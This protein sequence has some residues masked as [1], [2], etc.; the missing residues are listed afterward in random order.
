MT[1]QPLQNRPSGEE[2]LEHI[3][4]CVI[5]T[6]LDGIV[7]YWNAASERIFGYSREEMLGQP[8]VKI[9][10]SIVEDQFREDLETIKRNGQVEGKRKSITKD[11]R[12][13]WIDVHAMPFENEKGETLAVVAS[14]HDIEDLKNIENELEENKARAQAILETT[15]DGII[16]IDENA[17]I[18]S[19]NRAA[20]KI[21]G[22]TEE[23]VLGKNVN[24]LMPE[25]H[26]SEHDSFIDR[27]RKTGVRHIIGHRRELTGQR[28]DG[29][30][31]PL[32]LSVSEVQWKDKRIF[33][34]VVN[35]ISERRRLE[36]EILRISEEE[37]RNLGQDLHDGLGQML[38]GISLISKNLAL[39]LRAEGITSADEVL[40]IS[41][42]VKE[43][44]EYAKALAHG[45]VHIDFKEEGLQNALQQLSTQAKKL[46]NVNC[47]FHSDEYT[48]VD[49]SMKAMNLYRIAQEAI[50]NAVK[51]G[52]AENIDISLKS[53]NG[54]IK[55]SIKD[56]G[57]GF[58][59]SR[60]Q[61]KK[62]G[63]GIYIMQY[64]T[65]MMSGDFEISETDNQTRIKC[66]IPNNNM[67]KQNGK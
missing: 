7:T 51:H 2:I 36:K 35:D 8:L 44:D 14:A 45:L 33:T 38:T 30:L 49:N 48:R 39:K 24:M 29:S 17:Q 25:P 42:L 32:E 1:D 66:S 60:K 9:Y 20:T 63:M 65:N 4:Q 16:T 10:P 58:S 40:E 28:K 56:D 54:S 22:F 11:G 43:A 19:F 23:D 27:Y 31:F 3:S 50:S 18:L 5:T 57:I 12:V 15:V 13:I 41:N 34:G 64:R 37:R 67:E 53:D 61:E 6:D 47:T 52:K 46:F 55:L 62:K 26:R 21:F 59:Q